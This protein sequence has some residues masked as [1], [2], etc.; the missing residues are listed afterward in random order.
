MLKIGLH[1]GEDHVVSGHAWYHPDQ[2][3]K[4]RRTP[5][6]IRN[7]SWT[8]K[9]RDLSKV[10]VRCLGSAFELEDRDCSCGILLSHPE[11]RLGP[12]D[13]PGER[14]GGHALGVGDHCGHL[15]VGPVAVR[16]DRGHRVHCAHA[17]GADS[18]RAGLVDKGDFPVDQGRLA[19]KQQPRER[20][21]IRLVLGSP[22]VWERK[23]VPVP[24]LI[25]PQFHLEFFNG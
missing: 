22:C 13:S 4:V 25:A 1:L 12:V 19:D 16:S 21:A 5:D 11:G 10:Y 3:A 2:T 9:I 17:D 20:I 8:E 24:S 15:H 18:V 14:Q 23:E 6:S 7:R